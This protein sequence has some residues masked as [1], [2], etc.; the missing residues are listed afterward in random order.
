MEYSEET[1]EVIGT[2][3]V[4]VRG[5]SYVSGETF[6]AAEPEVEYLLYIGAVKRAG[7]NPEAPSVTGTFISKFGDDPRGPV[8][9]ARSTAPVVTSERLREPFNTRLDLPAKKEK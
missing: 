9:V 3:P 4:I 5:K 7:K 8:L 1:F 2:Q 6:S